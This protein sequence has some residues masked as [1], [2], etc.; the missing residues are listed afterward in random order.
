VSDVAKD[1]SIEIRGIPEVQ[2]FLKN[3]SKQKQRRVN[4]TIH[5]EGFRVEAEVKQSIAGQ[6]SEPRS[7]DTGRFLNSVQTDNSKYF[8]SRIFSNVRYAIHLEKGTS[9]I[10][11][12]RHFK[13]SA[14]RKRVEIVNNIS[15][16]LQ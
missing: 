5:R 6:R 2:A 14:N 13:N 3:S 8:Q 15:R 9:R 7:V 12:R 11:P 4:K 10:N 1:F 16:A